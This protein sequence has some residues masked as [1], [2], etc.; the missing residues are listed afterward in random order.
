[1]GGEAQR[2]GTFLRSLELSLELAL[3]RSHLGDDFI[4]RCDL[5]EELLLTRYDLDDLGRRRAAAFPMRYNLLR[6][7]L[8]RC[9]L[10]R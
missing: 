8:L 5:D 1:M 9:N 7:N 2:A 6:C 3:T 4:P 10:L